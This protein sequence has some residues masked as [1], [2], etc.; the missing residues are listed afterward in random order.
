MPVC[1]ATLRD[2]P[3][4]STPMAVMPDLTKMVTSERIRMGSQYDTRICGSTIM[5]TETKKMAPKMSLVPFIS[6]SI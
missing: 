5:P 2:S 1:T 6:F 4:S 3:E